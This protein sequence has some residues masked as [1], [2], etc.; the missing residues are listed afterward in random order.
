MSDYT[1][2]EMISEILVEINHNGGYNSVVLRQFLN[3]N[4]D[5]S[6]QDKNFITEVVNGTLRNIYYIDHVIKQFSKTPINKIK[7]F[8]LSVLRSS[9]YQICFMNTPNSASCNEAVKLVEKKGFI[10]L[11]AYVNAVLRNVSRNVDNIELPDENTKE[12]LSVKY[13][14]P[15]WIVNMWVAYYGFDTTKE[16][17]EINCLPPKVSIRI[18]TLKT[19][20]D[21]LENLMVDSGVLVE[22]GKYT[23]NA[24]YLKATSNIGELETFKNG[25]FHVQ[26]ESSQL[27]VEVL[28]PKE[29]DKILDLCSAPGGKTFTICEK[30]EDRGEIL[31]CDIFEHKL[32]L[33]NDGSERL[34]LSAIKT[35]LQDA[36][37]YVEEFSGYFDKVLVDAPCS[38]L[39]LLRKKPDIRSKKSGDEIDSLIEI[40]RKILENASK[41]VKV[42]GIIVYSTCTLSKKEN[43]KN[44]EWF[45]Q[46]FSEFEAVDISGCIDEIQNDTEKMGYVTLLPN[47]YKTDGFF[48]SKLIRKG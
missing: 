19:N 20:Y 38:G 2:R 11:K 10:Q 35:R 33:V 46:N 43:E 31:A 17:C 16:I 44:I 41:Y 29:G 25:M 47:I 23:N 40:Q 28:N 7:P 39:G 24:M 45:L 21:E 42:G 30:I 5:L 36:T 13:S 26:D 48:I 15:L 9:I 32:N 14:H 4:K 27:A 22:K 37:E 34:G 12:Y 1:P 18:N 8:I 6:S 3:K